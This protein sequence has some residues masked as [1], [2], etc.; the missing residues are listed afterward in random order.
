MVP[1]LGEPGKDRLDTR[2]VA[3]LIAGGLGRS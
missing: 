1:L 3:A 2:A